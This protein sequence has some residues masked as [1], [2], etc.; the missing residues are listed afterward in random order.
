LVVN[1]SFETTASNCANFGGEGFFTD[2]SATWDNANSNT[3]GDSCSSPDLFSECNELPSPF[4]SSPVGMPNNELGWQYSRT[5]T[6]HVGIITHEPLSN[7]REYIQG[8]TS[9]PLQAGQQY[10]VSFFISKGDKVPYATNN[11]GV[12]FSNTQY[13]R[14]ACPGT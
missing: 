1:P 5:G 12:Y 3:A 13:Q 9:A 8:R 11:I 7:Y 10:C 6:R 14:N 2:L 4:P